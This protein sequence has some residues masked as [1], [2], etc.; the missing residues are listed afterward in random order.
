MASLGGAKGVNTP[1]LAVE[2]KTGAEHDVHVVAP[3][4]GSRY[5]ALLTAMSLMTS[6]LEP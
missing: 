6:S 3:G 4:A 2:F 5:S 1:A